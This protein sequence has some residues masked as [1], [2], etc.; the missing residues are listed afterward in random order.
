MICTN[1]VF[2]LIILVCI[3][4]NS[5]TLAI[6][7]FPQQE[8]KATTLEAINHIVTWIFVVELIIKILG[9]GFYN[10]VT[11][12]LNQFDAIIVTFS[13]IEMILETEEGAMKI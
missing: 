11:D 6:D 7:D 1:Q 8:K 12:P 3:G 13:I 9:L 4:I 2:I 10:Y 5:V